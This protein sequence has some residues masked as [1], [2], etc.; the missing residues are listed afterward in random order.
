[1]SISDRLTIVGIF[2]N[3]SDAQRAVNE[4]R[5]NNFREDQIGVISPGTEFGIPAAEASA[6]DAATHSKIAEGAAIGAATGAGIGALWALG[7]A[8]SVLPPIGPVIAGGLLMSVL[9]SAGGAAAVGTLVGALIGLGVPEEEAR[10]YEGEVT[11]G[12]TLVTVKPDGRNF[13]ADAILR[14]N[15]AYDMQTSADPAGLRDAK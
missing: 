15:G 7:I 6:A 2:A 1:M 11:A 14:R 5:Q 8:A 12:R 13:E 9:A 10:F 4:L 3:R